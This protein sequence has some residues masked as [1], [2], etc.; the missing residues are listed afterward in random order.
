[1]A[2]HESRI[3]WNTPKRRDRVKYEG[4]RIVADVEALFTCTNH[5]TYDT[6]VD[7]CD[8]TSIFGDGCGAGGFV[9]GAGLF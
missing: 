6:D 3:R 8:V 2:T 7:F 5:Q 9:A 4:P 1:M